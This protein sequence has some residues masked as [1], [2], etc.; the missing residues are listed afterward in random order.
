MTARDPERFKHV[1]DD[2]TVGPGKLTARR[3]HLRADVLRR[4]WVAVYD[5]VAMKK[6]LPAD[7]QPMFLQK[8]VTRGWIQAPWEEALEQTLHWLWTKHGLLLGQARPPSAAVNDGNR[9][10]IAAFIEIAGECPKLKRRRV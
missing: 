5:H 9:A 10:A 8:A 3:I 7:C 1:V 4:R 2:V 6:D